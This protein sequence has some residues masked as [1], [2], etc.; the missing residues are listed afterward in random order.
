M[1]ED[2]ADSRTARTSA[3]EASADETSTHETSGDEDATSSYAPSYADHMRALRTS[4]IPMFSFGDSA[5]DDD[6]DFE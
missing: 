2:E 4:G 3:A 1:S 5:D 6:E